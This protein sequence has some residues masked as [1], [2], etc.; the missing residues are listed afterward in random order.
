MMPGKKQN[1]LMYMGIG[2]LLGL[3]VMFLTV[4]IVFDDFISLKRK[5][6]VVEN[7]TLTSEVTYDK[8]FVD[9]IVEKDKPAKKR[10]YTKEAIEKEIVDPIQN[11][12]L[13]DSLFPEYIDTLPKETDIIVKSDV[14]LTVKAIVPEG[15]KEKMNETENKLDSLIDNTKKDPKIKTSYKTEFWQSPINYSGYKR[16]GNKIVLFGI[17]QYNDA[18]LKQV[19]DK[20]YLD[21]LNSYY[22]LKNTQE[23]LP[24]IPVKLPKEVTGTNE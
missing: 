24:L 15:F 9:E 20:L 18:K 3:I 22:L 1:K 14:L 13:N 6:E 11:D 8:K 12:S 4:V 17:Y 21:Y 10:N 7:Q 19:D 2:F 16:S 23:F 5:N